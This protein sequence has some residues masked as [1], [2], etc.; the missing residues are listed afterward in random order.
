MLKPRMQPLA[1][2]S[3]EAFRLSV[4]RWQL[5]Q[6]GSRHEPGVQLAAQPGDAAAGQLAG[7]RQDLA[8][9][10]ALERAQAQA[11]V[12]RGIVAVHAAGATSVRAIRGPCLC[13]VLPLASV[14]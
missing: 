10:L 9:H 6:Y 12:G 3:P 5:A 7:L 1:L 8:A 11:Q 4:R 2:A 14:V 13:L